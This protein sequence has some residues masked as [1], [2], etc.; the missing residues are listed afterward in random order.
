MYYIVLFLIFI[1]FKTLR[2]YRKVRKYDYFDNHGIYSKEMLFSKYYDIKLEKLFE[3]Y[4]MENSGLV[5]GY[6]C[7][8]AMKTLKHL[9]DNSMDNKDKKITNN[10]LRLTDFQFL[11]EIV[12]IYKR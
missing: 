3:N 5:F 6:I 11:I 10:I 4:P 7:P 8:G 1:L 12:V 9:N 2:S